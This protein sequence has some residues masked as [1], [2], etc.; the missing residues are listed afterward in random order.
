MDEEDVSSNNDRRPV[1]WV[2]EH[3]AG[4]TRVAHENRW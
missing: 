3:R 2:D 1:R 4:P